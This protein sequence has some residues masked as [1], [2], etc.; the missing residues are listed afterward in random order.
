MR[1]K[2]SAEFSQIYVENIA[3]I[4]SL[5]FYR[6]KFNVLSQIKLLCELVLF[7]YSNTRLCIACMKI[8]LMARK[9]K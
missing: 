3:G 9:L 1:K 6:A 2:R 8:R 7:V 4:K 5:M